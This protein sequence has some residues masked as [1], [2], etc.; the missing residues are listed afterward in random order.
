MHPM[1][2]LNGSVK[3]G[4]DIYVYPNFISEEER[5]EILKHIESIPEDKWVG[6]FNE[7]GQGAE[8]AYQNINK[9][10][11]INK[12]IISML[13]A[14]IYLGPSL[15]PTRMKKGW[16]GPL[17]SDNYEF[18]NAL[19]SNKNLKEEEEFEIAENN[20]AGIII[21]FNDFVGGDIYYTKQNIRYQ[22]KA[23][24]LLIHS[25][26]KHCEH[27]VQEVKSNIRYSHSSHL[28]NLIK[29]KKGFSN[30]S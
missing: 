16:R 10:I 6:H 19:E 1:L 30:V 22:P 20:I 23:G 3:L 27:E 7:G 8:Y 13:D 5:I 21:Y 2:D 24:D 17:H 9:L 15:I 29:V 14:G 26:Q 25:S 18:L 28:F 12:R 11:P 4:E